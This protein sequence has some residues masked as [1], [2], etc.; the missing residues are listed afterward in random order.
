MLSDRQCGVGP[1]GF[2]FP[3]DPKDAGVRTAPG[4][5]GS[6]EGFE[7]ELRSGSRGRVWHA[8]VVR[9]GA[10]QTLLAR[11]A[12]KA[13]RTRTAGGQRRTV[14]MLA[15]EPQRVRQTP[16]AEKIEIWVGALGREEQ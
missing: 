12:G 3:D 1:L 4:A 7:R 5:Q 11:F 15:F 16:I 9:R 2:L 8:P 14:R 10:A 6:M 13:E